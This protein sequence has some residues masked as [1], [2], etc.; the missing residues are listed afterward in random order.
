MPSKELIDGEWMKICSC[1]ECDLAGQYQPVSKFHKDKWKKCGFKSICKKCR[2][3]KLRSAYKNQT[4][5]DKIKQISYQR[6][7]REKKREQLNKK[8]KKSMPL[9]H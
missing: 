7:Y 9:I 5:E 2:N 8:R 1:K 3:N 6:G 4:E